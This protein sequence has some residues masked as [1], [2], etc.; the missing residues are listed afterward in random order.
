MSS[1]SLVYYNLGILDDSGNIS[2]NCSTCSLNHG[3]ESTFVVLDADSYPST[4]TLRI[5]V[6]SS[7]GSHGGLASLQLFQ[8]GSLLF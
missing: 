7:H 4:L 2:S 3:S 5:E 6:L 8:K 1:V